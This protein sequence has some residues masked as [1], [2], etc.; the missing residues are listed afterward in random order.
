[1]FT[2]GNDS[3]KFDF[4]SPADCAIDC[5]MIY[6]T[7]EERPTAVIGFYPGKMIEVRTTQNLYY[8]TPEAPQ[9]ARTELGQFTGFGITTGSHSIR[10]I[11]GGERPFTGS[12]H[13]IIVVDSAT[14]K[15]GEPKWV[16]DEPMT[17]ML[18]CL[19]DS[20]KY[21]VTV[22]GYDKDK[23]GKKG[24]FIYETV[25]GTKQKVDTTFFKDMQMVCK[26]NFAYVLH[27]SNLYVVDVRAP[28]A[29]LSAPTVTTGSI[30]SRLA[31]FNEEIVL[32]GGTKLG[33]S[34]EDVPNL[35]YLING[36][37]VDGPAFPYTG[38]KMR[39]IFSVR[40]NTAPAS[41]AAG[42]D[43]IDFHPWQSIPFFGDEPQ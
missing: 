3:T 23:V 21:M 40:P 8:S 27:D 38:R 24:M 32:V 34:G 7:L 14:G 28:P 30:G 6:G 11:V 43:L 15:F 1:M 33:G 20:D 10:Y 36:R 22:G 35:R 12:T 41:G 29:N 37:L 26:D 5:H 39:D 19:A 42:G 2:G 18:V 4:W 16:L 31:D 25:D 13:N 9:W 17:D